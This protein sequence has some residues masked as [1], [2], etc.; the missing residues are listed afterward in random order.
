MGGNG[1]DA[2]AVGLYTSYQA[3]EKLS[4]YGRGELLT[5]QNNA[6]NDNFQIWEFTATVQYDLWQNVISRVE[7]RWDHGD[8]GKYFGGTVAGTPTRKNACMIAANITYKF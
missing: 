8:E 1:N 7:F 2:Y 5:F 3:T 4:F 6:P